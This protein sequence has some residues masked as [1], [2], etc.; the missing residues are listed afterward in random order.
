[1]IIGLIR[2]LYFIIIA[3]KTMHINRLEREELARQRSKSIFISIKIKVK[4]Y[5]KFILTLLMCSKTLYLL[6]I[7][8]CRLFNTTGFF[9]SNT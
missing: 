1:L 9:E 4:I 2:M 8:L 5:P 7:L 6:M 3:L